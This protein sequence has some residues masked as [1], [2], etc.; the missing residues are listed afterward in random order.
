MERHE[1]LHMNKECDW[2]STICSLEKQKQLY[3]HVNGSPCSHKEQPKQQASEWPYVS[4]DLSAEICFCKNGSSQKCTQLHRM[5]LGGK[6]SA[7]QKSERAQ[8]GSNWNF[9]I[10]HTVSLNPN[11]WVISD[12][13]ATVRRH[14]ATNASE[15]LDS[16]TNCQNGNSVFIVY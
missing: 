10:G 12:V 16:A 14:S 15:L 7:I 8:S 9:Q 11:F 4:F 2:H 13:P 5:M 3:L 1:L 6:Q